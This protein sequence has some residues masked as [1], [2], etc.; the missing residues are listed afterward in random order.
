MGGAENTKNISARE[1][2]DAV[3]FPAFSLG[4]LAAPHIFMLGRYSHS[5][6]TSL[7]MYAVHFMNFLQEDF[8][9]VPCGHIKALIW[10]LK[11]PL[12]TSK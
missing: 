6:S 10:H 11:R 9:K 3:H 1:F 4:A 8:F 5:N 12:A 2:L 7:Y